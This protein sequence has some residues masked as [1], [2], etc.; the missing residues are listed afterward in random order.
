MSRPYSS[1]PPPR[2]AIPLPNINLSGAA[3]SPA[4]SSD[5]LGFQ[6]SLGRG[7][8]CQDLFPVLPCRKSEHVGSGAWRPAGGVQPSLLAT[9]FPSLPSFPL[10]PIL[11]PSLPCPPHCSEWSP[12]AQ[13]RLVAEVCVWGG[14]GVHILP[15]LRRVLPATF[16]CPKIGCLAAQ[17]RGLRRMMFPARPLPMDGNNS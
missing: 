13:G 5:L 12:E 9:R 11:M 6:E 17:A 14:E 7:P 16:S 3:P 8:A 2:P 4:S 10:L 15:C 1:P